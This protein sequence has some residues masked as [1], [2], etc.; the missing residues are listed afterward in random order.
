MS[1]EPEAA[2]LGPAEEAALRALRQGP[3]AAVGLEERVVGALRAQGLLAGA[4]HQRPHAGRRGAWLAAGLAAA[5]A[6]FALGWWARAAVPPPAQAGEEYVLLLHDTGVALPAAEEGRIVAEYG[7]WAAELRA[8]GVSISGQK[9]EDARTLLGPRGRS[10]EAGPVRGALAGYF[11]LRAD[12]AAAAL[13]IAESCPHLR[14]GGSVE[15]RRIATL[16][17][18]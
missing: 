16:R 3:D 7:A 13:A 1:E 18:G 6:A 2:E 10:L 8:R 12:G 11:L 5:L 4:A 9:L 17:R 15:V 14:H